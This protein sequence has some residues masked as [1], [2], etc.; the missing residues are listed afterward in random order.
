LVSL[1]GQA[2]ITDLH[3]RSVLLNDFDGSGCL[4][5]KVGRGGCV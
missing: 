2:V 5:K 3:D 1:Q 4:K